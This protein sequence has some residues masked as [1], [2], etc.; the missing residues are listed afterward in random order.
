M[1]IEDRRVRMEMKLFFM[2]KII[3]L[4]LGLT[5]KTVILCSIRITKMF[6]FIISLS[7][8]SLASVPHYEF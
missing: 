6:N 7:N 2:V 8:S 3:R 1:F 4:L 5:I